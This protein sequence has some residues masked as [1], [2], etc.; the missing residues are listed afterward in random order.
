MN[1]RSWVVM[2]PRLAACLFFLFLLLAC[3]E[4]SPVTQAPVLAS[5]AHG[6]DVYA[7]HCVA[8]HGEKGFGDGVA[9]YLLKPKP[10]DFSRVEFRLAT[11]SNG[12]PT[13]EDL[14]NTI[15]KG[16]L[17]SSM[18]P[19]E[20]LPE[21]DRRSLVL[22]V[23]KLTLEGK[24]ARLV[25]DGETP[26]EA[27][28]IAEEF[29]RVGENVTI[30]PETKNDAASLARGKK[31]FEQDCVSCHDADGRGRLKRDLE[32]SQ[33]YPILARD[34]TK[35]I[36]KGGAS[37]KEL[38]ARF[39]AGMAGTPMP[40][41]Q[42]MLKDPED[43]WGLIHYTRSFIAKGVQ[44]RIQQKQKTL[45]VPKSSAKLGLDP[46]AAVWQEQQATWLAMMP[47]W[48]RDDRIEG[49]NLELLHDGERIAFRL[50]WE[51]KSKNEDQIGQRAFGDA[52]AIQFTEEANPPF[53]GMGAKGEPINIWHWKAAWETDLI[54]HR[55]VEHSFPNVLWD[56]YPSLMKPPYG[57]QSSVAEFATRDHDPRFLTGWGSGNPMSNPS[58]TSSVEDVVAEGLGTLTSIN[59]AAQTVVGKAS[60][61][62]GVWTVVMLRDLVPTSDARSAGAVKFSPEQSLSVAFAVWDGERAD[63]DG[64]KSVTIWHRLIMKY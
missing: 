6:S 50:S 32:D 1:R 31:I 23:E 59:A 12:M 19:W 5:L 47:L 43:L 30:P 24:V 49:L 61:Q 4:S 13:D 22:F 54:E 42:D 48:W 55:D 7:R 21:V 34:F 18:P 56:F 20:H 60:W 46:A 39:I 57:R 44:Q 26:D 8:C 41:F 63:R 51:D 40:S 62:G 3:G 35:G 17:G 2:G 45:T 14:Y 37:G 33:G 53:F 9:A 28:E 64:Q 15:S 27:M 25:A 58:R 52:L 11:T 29:C 10:R 16:M 38:A 36:F